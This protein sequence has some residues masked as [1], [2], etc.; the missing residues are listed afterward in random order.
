MCEVNQK[1]TGTQKRFHLTLT[2]NQSG[3]P[4]NKSNEWGMFCED[5]C[6]LENCKKG[7]EQLK[8][9]ISGFNKAWDNK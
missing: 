9:F 5:M 8:S 3:K 7:T 6:D 4:I 2:C 1:T